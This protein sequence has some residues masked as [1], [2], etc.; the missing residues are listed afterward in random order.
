MKVRI[1][2]DKKGRWQSW[3]AE[4]QGD[5]WHGDL[6]GHGADAGEATAELKANVTR[7]IAE[8]QTFMQT[9]DGREVT[10]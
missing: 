4:V 9:I 8:L 2:D 6:T 5:D 1:T 3:S 7:R 10:P